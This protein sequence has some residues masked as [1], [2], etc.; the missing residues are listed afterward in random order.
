VQS[1]IRARSGV[2]CIIIPA[3]VTRASDRQKIAA[4][5]EQYGI[6]LL[7][8]SA[9]ITAHGKFE[10][11]RP[12]VLEKTMEINFYSPVYLTQLLL[13]AMRRAQGQRKIVLISTPSAL[14]GIPHRF[15]YSASKAAGH[16]WME[17]IRVELHSENFDTLLFCPDTHARHFAPADLPQTEACFPSRRQKKRGT[18]RMWQAGCS[19]PSAETSASHS[20]A[21]RVRFC[22]ICARWRQ[23]SWKNA[24]AKSLNH[25]KKC[26][27]ARC[28]WIPL[29][30]D[31]AFYPPSFNLPLAWA[32]D[33][34][35]P[36]LLKQVQN[37]TP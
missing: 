11:T 9:G 22:T 36:V 28:T 33:F 31:A 34:T 16:A 29:S 21:T 6:S 30:V 5:A 23:A 32:V 8:H 15:A 19:K 18:R 26:F 35:L 25:P 17:S 3:D 7:V 27:Q 14:H 20:P 13:P 24:C 1:E 12:E 37:L 4:Q 2:D 10:H